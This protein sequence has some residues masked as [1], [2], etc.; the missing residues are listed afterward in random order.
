[1][2]ECK[3][4]PIGIEDFKILRERNCYFIFTAD[5]SNHSFDKAF[6]AQKHVQD[7]VFT[8]VTG[9]FYLFF[10]WRKA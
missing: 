4:I 2:N 6:K 7:Y 10:M 3:K 8:D 1:M 5:K 9:S